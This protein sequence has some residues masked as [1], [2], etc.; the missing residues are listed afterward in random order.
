MRIV[1][2]NTNDDNRLYSGIV[3]ASSINEYTQYLDVIPE[4]C[5]EPG[6][7]DWKTYLQYCQHT[8]SRY[9]RNRRG[10][11]RILRIIRI[12]SA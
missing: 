4:G 12:I 3:L 7:K 2:K 8:S 6:I 9:R 10:F 5:I 11:R 1:Y